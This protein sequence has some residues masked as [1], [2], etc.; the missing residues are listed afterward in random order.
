M[1]TYKTGWVLVLSLLTST[2]SHAWYNNEQA[3]STKGYAIENF[4]EID[5]CENNDCS[6]VNTNSVIAPPQYKNRVATSCPYWL[7]R[8]IIDPIRGALR[9]NFD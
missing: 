3:M 9:T 1:S 8:Y 6:R 2:A 7:R 4:E 5:Y